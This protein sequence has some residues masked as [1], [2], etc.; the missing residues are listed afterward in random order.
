MS[1]PFT[2]DEM[3]NHPMGAILLKAF[4]LA[5]KK[6]ADYAHSADV[7]ANFKEAS[8]M[9]VP[10]SV[11]VAIRLSDKWMRFK[12]GVR[13]NWDMDVKDE[14]MTDTTLDIINY[15]AIYQALKTA[16]G[17]AIDVAPSAPKLLA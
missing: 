5:L 11:G 16:E 12:K 3:R 2:L 1:Q 9:G 15:A 13:T 8:S 14:G 6:N 7:F 10:P 4:E 17:K